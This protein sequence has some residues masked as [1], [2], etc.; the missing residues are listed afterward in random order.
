MRKPE[1]CFVFGAGE[2]TEL[3]ALPRAEDFVIAADGGIEYALDCGISADLAVGDFDSLTGPLPEGM[4][5][6][7]L[8]REKDDTDMRAALNI[9]IERGFGTFFIYGG[10]G[11]RIDH[12]IANM[13]CIADLARLG[14]RAYLF[15]R[16]TVATAIS[17]GGISFAAGA[18]GTVSV[19]SHTDTSRGVCETGLKYPLADAVLTNTFPIGVSNEFIGE[20]AAISVQEGT[21]IVVYPVSAH[22]WTAGSQI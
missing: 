9:G 12:S 2:R 1:I 15:G 20:P 17:G 4:E 3:P 6:V 18:A 22:P 14:A 10:L 8:H 21:L 11:G 19:F 5:V 7:A 16:D 13:Q